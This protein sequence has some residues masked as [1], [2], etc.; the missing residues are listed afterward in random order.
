M[1]KKQTQII[2]FITSLFIINL[3]WGCNGENT[4][5]KVTCHEQCLSMKNQQVEVFFNTQFIIV[6]KQ[7]QIKIT[8]KQPITSM[9]IRGTNMNMGT[10][11][12]IYELINNDNGNFVYQSSFM[13]GLCSEPEMQWQL[14]I[15]T[16][17][18]LL[19][20]FDFSSYW[21]RPA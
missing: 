1:I 11:P 10:L 4:S 14:A 16:E 7:Y 3:L 18:S 20:T 15:E 12:L 2:Q 13:L 5:T 9:Y 8:S 21:K 19:N 6:E 17:D